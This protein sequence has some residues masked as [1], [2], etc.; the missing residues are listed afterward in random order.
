MVCY[1]LTGHGFSWITYSVSR[2]IYM[3][4]T[5]SLPYEWSLLEQNWGLRWCHESYLQK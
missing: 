3:K 4:D 1:Q 2:L 5:S